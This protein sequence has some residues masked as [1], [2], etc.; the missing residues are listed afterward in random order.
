MGKDLTLPVEM[1]PEL[2]MFCISLRPYRTVELIHAPPVVA[3]CVR[4]VANEVN[5]LYA[6]QENFETCS[7]DKLG[8]L[9]ALQPNPIV[10]ACVRRLA[11][12]VNGLYA[13]QENFETCYHDKLGVLQA[14][15]PNPIVAA[16]VRRLANEVNGLYAR[17]ENVEIRSNE[18]LGVFQ[19]KMSFALFGFENKK[20]STLGNLFCMRLLEELHKMG[21]NLQIS[22]DLIRTS[23]SAGTLFFR[24]VT[25]ERPTAKVVCIAPREKNTIVLLNHSESVKSMV[26]NAIKDTWP[27]GIK[28]QKENE[29]LGHTVHYIKMNGHPWYTGEVFNPDI[30]NNRIINRIAG[31]LSRINLRLVGGINIKGRADS[32]FFIEDPGSTAQFSSISLCQSNLLGL[33]DCKEER[34]YVQQAIAKSGFRIEDGSEKEHVAKMKLNGSP[35]HCSGAEAVQSCQL[36]AGISE[37]MLQRGWALTDAHTLTHAIASGKD[38]DDEKSML[39]FRRCTPNTASFSCICLH[40]GTFVTS[41]DH[42]RLINFSPHDQELLKTCIKQNYLPGVAGVWQEISG[43]EGNSV[44]FDLVGSPWSSYGGGLH[45]RSLLVHLFAAAINLGFQIVAST[46]VSSKGRKNSSD[47]LVD[48]HSIYLIKIPTQRKIEKNLL[49]TNEEVMA[50]ARSFLGM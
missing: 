14:L 18:K 40:K 34:Q 39:L 47:N 35:W 43:V 48:V 36:V 44:K 1:N 20:R 33:V 4:K 3:D 28:M 27:K 22:S 37:A 23:P 12:E 7:H 16:C 50:M 46:D 15:Q 32:L 17:Q 5:G 19:I 41:T 29:V 45:A 31:N 49:P 42:I 25:S 11:N 30:D 38:K 8:V 24:K 2:G 13:R 21:F 10:A 6:R 9:Q 26:E